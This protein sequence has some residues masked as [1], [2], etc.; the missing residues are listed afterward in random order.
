[1]PYQDDLKLWNENIYRKLLKIIIY[2][3]YLNAITIDTGKRCQQNS[4]QVSRNNFRC[5]MQTLIQAY[6]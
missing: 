4:L 5:I 6:Y 2:I 3:H 1:M